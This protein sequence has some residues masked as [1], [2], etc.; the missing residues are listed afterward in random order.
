M[1]R[2][3]PVITSRKNAH[4][5]ETAAL[6][7]KKYRYER[8]VFLIEGEKLVI[9]AFEKGLPIVELFLS[10]EKAED[11]L[12]RLQP[13]GGKAEYRDLAV[14]TLSRDCFLKISSEKSPQGVIAVI[15][16]LDFF[17]RKTII[18]NDDI[19]SLAGM[20]VVMLYAMQDPGNLGAVIRSAVAFGADCIFLS[21]DC[22]DV[23][24]SKTIR[25]A[26]GSLFRT[27]ICMVEDVSSAIAAMQA[28]GRR[29]LAA[30]LRENAL[31]LS[32]A[33]LSANDCVIIGNEGHGIPRAISDMCDASVYLP[34]SQNAESLNAAVAAAIF[35]W[36]QSKS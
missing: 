8:E 18:Y 31:P 12:S 20:R 14:Y 23:Y 32:S 35:L 11:V 29:V 1:N 21:A 33:G 30:E 22:A 3:M 27:R 7:E 17:K 2:V 6:H 36:E 25:A 19:F 4:V 5:I 28:C 34:I 9:E 26:M 24:N 15:K 10:E 13:F 16:Y